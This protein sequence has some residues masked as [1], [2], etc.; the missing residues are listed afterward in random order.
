MISFKHHLPAEIIVTVP[1]QTFLYKDDVR[2]VAQWAVI[3]AEIWLMNMEYR[4][5]KEN[6]T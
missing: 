2:A 1:R 4:E 6:V 3:M 5:S